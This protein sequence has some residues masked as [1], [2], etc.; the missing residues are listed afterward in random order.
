M[1]HPDP[2]RHCRNAGLY[3]RWWN[4][5]ILASDATLAKLR[6]LPQLEQDVYAM[7]NRSA[8]PWGECY[9]GANEM[10]WRTG[11]TVAEVLRAIER[12][13]AVGM[14]A[15]RVQAKGETI[16]IPDWD[17]AEYQEI[18]R[19]TERDRDAAAVAAIQTEGGPT[20]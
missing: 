17:E 12:L 2:F 1:T 5:D 11:A 9:I 10:A 15:Q 20:K 4:R 6:T 7:I 13:I 8:N 16:R 18:V 14:L 3:Q 19:M